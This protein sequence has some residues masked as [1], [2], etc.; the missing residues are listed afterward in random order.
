MGQFVGHRIDVVKIA[1]AIHSAI[2]IGFHA[3]IELKAG[4]TLAELGTLVWTE[5][6]GADLGIL[7]E[8]P[9]DGFNRNLNYIGISQAGLD[10][11]M[12]VLIGHLSPAVYQD[13]VFRMLTISTGWKK[14]V[15][16]V[17]M[18]VERELPAAIIDP[19]SSKPIGV[20]AAENSKPEG[21]FFGTIDLRNRN[22][23][24]LWNLFKDRVCH[25]PDN[26]ELICQ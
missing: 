2:P 9:A 6:V 13:I 17:S 10:W 3:I 14:I 22:C 24:A 20:T 8:K 12:S 15:K 7:V 16:V 23:P 19:V 1:V 18:A 5:A 25:P 4:R 26:T 21:R 11:C